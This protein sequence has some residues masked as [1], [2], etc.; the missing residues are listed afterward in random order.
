[1]L[2]LASA[3][4]TTLSNQEVRASTKFSTP[5]AAAAAVAT[6]V[7]SVGPWHTKCKDMLHRHAYMCSS[8][9]CCWDIH[10]LPSAALRQ[11]QQGQGHQPV[12]PPSPPPTPIPTH[13]HL[14]LRSPPPGTPCFLCSSPL[15]K[16]FIAPGIR[17]SH[18]MRSGISLS[19]SRGARLSALALAWPISLPGCK[20]QA[21]LQWV[22]IL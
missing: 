14:L 7:P 21:V 12:I 13:K 10:L 5:A 18:H 9:L 11:Q 17:L 16:S 19:R 3:S 15:T 1:M 22:L 2:C 20:G 6:V 8:D 4:F